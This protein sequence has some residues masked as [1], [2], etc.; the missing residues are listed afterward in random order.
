MLLFLAVN[1]KYYD[2]KGPCTPLELLS[3]VVLTYGPQALKTSLPLPLDTKTD[4]VAENII[5]RRTYS[6]MKACEQDG[7]FDLLWVPPP[8]ADPVNKKRRRRGEEELE[9]EEAQKRIRQRVVSPEAWGLLEWL[10]D[11]WDAD[12]RH[13]KDRGSHDEK[14]E[15]EHSLYNLSKKL[16]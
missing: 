10:L 6:R 11:L 7:V 3:K 12:G 15:Q 9:A 13:G 2:P 8:P 1:P 5:E 14:G 4:W 16:C